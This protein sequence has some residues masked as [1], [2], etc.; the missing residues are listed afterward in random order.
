[1]GA[2]EQEASA[3]HESMCSVELKRRESWRTEAENF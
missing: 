2:D 1:M 3:R